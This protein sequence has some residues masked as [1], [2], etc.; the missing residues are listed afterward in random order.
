MP[1]VPTGYA[2]VGDFDGDGH[3][4]L[5]SGHHRTVAFGTVVTDMVLVRGAVDGVAPSFT[6]L[7]V[8]DVRI[9][10]IVGWS[11]GDRTGDGRSDLVLNNGAYGYYFAPGVA[12]GTPASVTRAAEGPW[13]AHD[14]DG[15]GFADGLFGGGTEDWTLY[16]GAADG[17]VVSVRLGGGSEVSGYVR[18]GYRPPW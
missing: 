5:V 10:A 16:R 9:D 15:D 14:V 2:R 3:P 4:D 6:V 11:A 18:R 13:L 17:S 7:R 1:N 8:G 12:D